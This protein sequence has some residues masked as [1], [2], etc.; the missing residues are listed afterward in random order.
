MPVYCTGV[1]KKKFMYKCTQKKVSVQVYTKPVYCKV[2]TKP[3][4]C[5]SIQNKFAAQVYKKP[6]YCT[7]VHKTSTLCTSTQGLDRHFNLNNDK[8]YHL[9]VKF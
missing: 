3:V 5:T 8:L 1:H 4:Y 6:V 9:R 2:Q 7:S